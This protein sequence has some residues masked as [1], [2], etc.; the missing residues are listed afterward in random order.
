MQLEDLALDK[1]IIKSFKSKPILS[2]EIFRGEIMHPQVRAQLLKIA[3][4]FIDSLDIEVS[5]DDVTLTGSLAN[6]N[7]SDFSD[8]DLHIL[9][10][11]NKLGKD[12]ELLKQYF[13]AKKNLW[14]E[15]HNILVQGFETEVYIQDTT[16]KHT[17]TGVYSVARNKWVVTPE[18]NSKAIDKA[19]ILEKSRYYAKL[20]D[21]LVMQAK[22][23]K[24]VRSEIDAL[25]GRLKNFRQ[26]GLDAGGEYST[27]NLTFKLLR[28]NGYIE[29]LFSLKR[30]LLDKDLSS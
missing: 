30:Q 24:D 16:E 6:Y 29:K 8:I 7:W 12:K 15:T 28:R 9:I 4:E 18:K 26:A 17:S 27:E 1:R 14:N 11:F 3:K 13:D 25:Q 23:G 5:V 20:I 2:P 21:K 10:D 22:R 19:G